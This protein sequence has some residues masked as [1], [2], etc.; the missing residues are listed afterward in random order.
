MANPV[1]DPA[2]QPVWLTVE[3]VSK[4]FGGVA[5]LRRASL[6]LQRGEVHGLVGANGAG[7]STLVRLLAGLIVPDEG[8]IEVDGTTYDRITMGRAREL[9]FSFIHQELSL[10]PHFDAV[11]NALLGLPKPKRLGLV[12]WRA[13]ERRVRG[14]MDRLGGSFSLT[15]PVSMLT[16]ADR[17]LVA[18]ARALLTEAR[19]IAMDEPTASLA[20][21]EGARLHQIVR[22]LTGD[23][24]T[25][26]YV[27]HKLEEVQSLCDRVTVFRGGESLVTLRPGEISRD[28]LVEHIVG[29]AVVREQAGPNEAQDSEPLLRVSGLRRLPTVRGASLTLTAGEIVG[30]VGLVGAGR[31]ELARLIV[32]ADTPEA[33][34][35][36]L[37]G[38]PLSVRS[39]HDALRHRIGYVPEERRSQGLL[40]T[41]SVDFN[42]S[43]ASLQ[44]NRA[45]SG[46]PFVRSSRSEATSRELVRRLGV[47]TPSLSTPV[48]S[49]SGGNQQKVLIARYVAAGCRVLI[50]DEP[51]RGV[52]V[53]A[54]EEMYGVMNELAASGIGVIVISS[55]IEE[56]VGRCTRFLVMAQGAIVAEAGEHATKE[57]LTRLSYLVPERTAEAA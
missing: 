50:F 53:G 44:Q 47:V 57:E 17:W 48:G 39:P 15:K 20:E 3:G 16:V 13:A 40:L 29:H 36:Q 51:T 2:G 21:E 30:L 34:E 45:M 27:S 54:R 35:I 5:A 11:E 41:K 33:G 7:K 9:G 8:T 26:I 55:E 6:D 4:R 56:L 42:I 24:I 32:G 46:L 52:D 12:S 1:H 31:T 10:V 25:I 14:A 28:E 38:R 43:L 37:D 22:R 49:L 23:G 18:I 19:M